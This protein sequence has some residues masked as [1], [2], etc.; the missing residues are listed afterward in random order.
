VAA[1]LLLGC[2][3]GESVNPVS[4]AGSDAAGNV[5]LCK[6]TEGF[7]LATPVFDVPGGHEIQNCYFYRVPDTGERFVD[8][9]QVV[10]NTGSHHMNIFRVQGDE[11]ALSKGAD[12]GTVVAGADG[13]GECFNSAD[14]SAWPLVINSQQSSNAGDSGE[15]DW[16]MPMSPRGQ[17][18]Q[19]F[20]P[21]ELLMV[22][23]HYV[24]ATTQTSALGRGEVLANFYDADKGTM[25]PVLTTIFA[26]HP[27]IEI[28]P[29]IEGL[30]SFDVACNFDHPDATIVG[31][32]SHF[33]SRGKDF[34]ISTGTESGDVDET[35]YD[36]KAWDEPKMAFGLGVSLKKGDPLLYTCSYEYPV[37]DAKGVPCSTTCEDVDT[38]TPSCGLGAQCEN[39]MFT[40]H[41]GNSFCFGPIVET[42][43]HCNAFIYLYADEPDATF[44]GSHVACF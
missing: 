6:P 32:N 31:A 27:S 7:Q 23:T 28:R 41:C 37:A 34:T 43:E 11:N 35:F 3:D 19:K 1:A 25:G 2:S 17:V 15:V 30:Q 12:D 42:M 44:E 22:Q 18:V 24:N 10:Q 20:E 26:S 38:K 14:W 21:G 4:C 29:D 9:I 39:F 36:N 8:R 13:Q 33:H 40:P 16:T 5:T